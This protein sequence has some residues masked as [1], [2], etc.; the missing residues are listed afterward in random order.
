VRG[1][2]FSRAPGAAESPGFS[3]RGPISS[4]P[5]DQERPAVPRV[6]FILS[7]SNMLTGIFKSNRGNS[8]ALLLDICSIP[9]H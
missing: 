4:G 7:S 3:P 5:Y 9:D 2:G 1:H 8:A 6:N